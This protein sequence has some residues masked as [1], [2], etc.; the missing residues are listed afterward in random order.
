MILMLQTGKGDQDEGIK[1]GSICEYRL[2]S[3]GCSIS[4]YFFHSHMIC[5]LLP[6]LDPSQLSP[7]PKEFCCLLR[8]VI[9]SEDDC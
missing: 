9:P 6:S 2:L 3:L 1:G 7:V 5:F 8:P 4:C